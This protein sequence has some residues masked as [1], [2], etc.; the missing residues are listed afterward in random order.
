MNEYI[1]LEGRTGLRAKTSMS[2]TNRH[3]ILSCVWLPYYVVTLVTI[4]LHV[5]QAHPV[6]QCLISSEW[7]TV[8]RF[9]MF[10]FN[11]PS[12]SHRPVLS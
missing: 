8:P 3:G 11:C 10:S 5:F 1:F 12:V 4:Y 7:A 2:D 6:Q 9:L